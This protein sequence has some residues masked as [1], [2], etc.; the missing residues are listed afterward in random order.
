LNGA[1]KTQ[2][3][4]LRSLRKLTFWRANVDYTVLNGIGE[5]L[6]F[7]TAICWKFPPLVLGA[8]IVPCTA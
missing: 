7:S 2:D 4:L 8:V 1:H 6:T 5:F 3:K